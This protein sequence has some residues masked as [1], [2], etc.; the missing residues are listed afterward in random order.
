M[1]QT[2]ICIYEGILGSRF[3]AGYSGPAW[4]QGDQLAANS[5]KGE[6]KEKGISFF[7]WIV[8]RLDSIDPDYQNVFKILIQ[9]K[10]HPV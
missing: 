8:K 2:Q 5:S 9:L 1:L 10:S 7:H 4:R 6:R 3:K